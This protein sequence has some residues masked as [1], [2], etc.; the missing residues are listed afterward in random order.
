MAAPR[1]SHWSPPSVYPTV[2][3]QLGFTWV[4]LELGVQTSLLNSFIVAAFT[5][6][7]LPA[8]VLLA[9]VDVGDGVALLVGVAVPVGVA[10]AA[11]WSL[12]VAVAVGGRGSDDR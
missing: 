12:D 3:F 2:P 9:A 1:L 5:A 7:A 8:A 6:D 11:R 4:G 10:V